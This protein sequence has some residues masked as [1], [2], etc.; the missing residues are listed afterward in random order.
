M[1]EL[2]YKIDQVEEA[3][4]WL[5]DTI[6]KR[7]VV[8][9]DAPM[10]AGKTTLVA[11]IARMLGSDDEPNSPTFSI[12]NEYTLPD[13]K[14][15]YHFDFYRMEDSQDVWEIGIAD[16]L[17]SGHLCLIEWPRI[18]LPFLPEDAVVVR[19]NINPDSSRTLQIL[20]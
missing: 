15:I 7:K 14:M 5:L 12:V 17:E 20:N 10:G 9:F 13:N 8:L 1:K 4:R 11:Q 16:Y 2:T 18:A 6:G 19:I 3:A